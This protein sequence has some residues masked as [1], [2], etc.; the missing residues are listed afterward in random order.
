MQ[1]GLY[2]NV[3]APLLKDYILEVEP[4]KLKLNNFHQIIFDTNVTLLQNIS[5]LVSNRVI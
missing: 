5:L 1:V 2:G 3:D 4:L